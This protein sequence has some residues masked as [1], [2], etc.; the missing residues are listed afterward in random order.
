MI[1]AL[2]PLPEQHARGAREIGEGRRELVRRAVGCPSQV[3]TWRAMRLAE[4]VP[5]GPRLLGRQ[6]CVCKSSPKK[7]C[8]SLPDLPEIFAKLIETPGDA[9]GNSYNNA[10]LAN[11][12]FCTRIGH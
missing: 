4:R 1:R 8:V 9:M 7:R 6:R 11:E 12:R 5:S 2:A 10:I 3:G